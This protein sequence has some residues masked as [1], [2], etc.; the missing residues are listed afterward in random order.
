MSDGGD[1]G[2]LRTGYLDKLNSSGWVGQW[3]RR[4]FVVTVRGVHRYIRAEDSPLFGEERAFISVGDIAQ[5]GTLRDAQRFGAKQGLSAADA[6]ACFVLRLTSGRDFVLRARSADDARVWVAS[7]RLAVKNSRMTRSSLLQ[8][9][10]VADYALKS[11]EEME[12]LLRRSSRGNSIASEAAAELPQQGPLALSSVAID[13]RLV[14]EGLGVGVAWGDAVVLGVL[15]SSGSTVSIA[16]NDDREFSV[17]RGALESASLTHQAATFEFDVLSVQGDW[18][19]RLRAAST[20]PSTPLRTPRRAPLITP[21]S[22]MQ[23]PLPPPSISALAGASSSSSSA[24]ARP[25]S[26]QAAWGGRRIA[27]VGTTSAV[28]SALLAQIGAQLA[29]LTLAA[30]LVCAV[31]WASAPPPSSPRPPLAA[32]EATATTG[33]AAT[34]IAVPGVAPRSAVVESSSEESGGSVVWSLRFLSLAEAD[35]SAVRAAEAAG[36]ASATEAASVPSAETVLTVGGIVVSPPQLSLSPSARFLRATRGN[37]EEAAVRWSA[38]QEWRRENGVDALVTTPQPLW[39][40]IKAAHPTFYHGWARDGTPVY[41]ELLGDVNT[42]ALLDA[43]ITVDQLVWNSV[44]GCEWMW[45]VCER[46]DDRQT[47]SVLDCAGIGISD[48]L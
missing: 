39:P 11:E 2:I 27:I 38:T 14:L 28:A 32:A 4:F 23:S 25:S 24:A 44:F 7:V 19:L 8:R 13:G 18:T 37:S 6:A 46:D 48:F 45:R 10:G 17:T 29:A 43:G 40:T 30:L 42:P 1:L 41:Y 47:T 31:A 35:A 12:A 5:C 26:A 34:R 15:R 36:A 21:L 9:S 3:L 22:L 33:A 16:L 20:T